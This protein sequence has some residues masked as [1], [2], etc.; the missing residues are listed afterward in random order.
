MN[1]RLLFMGNGDYR[2]RGCEAITRGSL[3]IFRRVMPDVVF[4]DSYFLYENIDVESCLGPDVQNSPVKYPR[5]WSFKWILL[6]VFLMVSSRL[7]GYVLFFNSGKSVAKSAAVF[8]LGGDNYS[9]DYGVPKRFLSMGDFVKRRKKPFIIWGASIGP[10]SSEPGFESRLI[11]N[12]RRNVDLI[13]VRE[14]ES[15]DYLVGK[16]LGSKVH[17]MADPAFIMEPEVCTEAL[18]G[19]SLP[20]AF[21]AVNFSPSMSK[22]V[23]DGNSERW[24]SICHDTIERL[25]GK[26]KMPIILVPHVFIDK[27]FMESALFKL[28]QKYNDIKMVNPN[29]NAAQM[30]WIISKAKVVIAARTHATIASFS[31]CV[32]TLS[33][34]YSLKSIG[35]NKLMFGNTD[36]LLY[37]DEINADAILKKISHII[38]E[39]KFIKETLSVKKIEMN[40]MAESAGLVV[41]EYISRSYG[42]LPISKH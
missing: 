2:N 9:L 36:Y 25:Y 32:P 30:K 17:L 4:T 20:E 1:I 33:L 39:E 26:Y 21:I 8:S 3:E 22:C 5:R 38:K 12:F 40:E 10:F 23:T 31:T 41:K 18:L 7:A 37:G 13:F 27:E 28:M 11:K 16:G 6:N 19:I 29:L 15:F 34:G 24:K 42:E 35:L 14:K